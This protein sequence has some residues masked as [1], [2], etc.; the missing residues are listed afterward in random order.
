MF[1][2][3]FVGSSM[4]WVGASFYNIKL[5]SAYV[6]QHN[7]KCLY[8]ELLNG[9]VWEIREFRGNC[10]CNIYFKQ[11]KEQYKSLL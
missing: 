1:A 4:S 3:T 8:V 10:I 2:D 11:I 5:F 6:L 7:V 9:L